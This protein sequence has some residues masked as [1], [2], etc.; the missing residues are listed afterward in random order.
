MPDLFADA[1]GADGIAV[2]TE[3]YSAD[4]QFRDGESGVFSI[5]RESPAYATGDTTMGL[6]GSVVSDIYAGADITFAST[7]NS[8]NTGV[9][10][11]GLQTQ[12]D[13]TTADGNTV[14]RNSSTL[15]TFKVVSPSLGAFEVF[16]DRSNN[17]IEGT[18]GTIA[19][20]ATDPTSVSTG[21]TATG[22]DRTVE[23]VFRAD[24]IEEGTTQDLDIA[25]TTEDNI[26]VDSDNTFRIKF[27][28]EDAVVTDE[29]G[30]IRPD[31][32]FV[33]VDE[34][35]DRDNGETRE[36]TTTVIQVTQPT[37]TVVTI[38][39]T[40]VTRTRRGS[41]IAKCPREVP[42]IG[43]DYNLNTLICISEQYDRNVVNV[44]FGL[45]IGWAQGPPAIRLR[46]K[47]VYR[48]LNNSPSTD[49]VK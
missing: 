36:V 22:E 35:T 47:N 39:G 37:F 11:A 46:G 21:T 3:N 8:R 49:Y 41:G 29:D 17:T 14:S 32:E 48:V 25:T 1:A 13:V 20:S 4:P 18:P 9:Q 10:L 34:T 16:Y 30:N 15:Q 44:P 6:A 27:D 24:D 19:G 28:I 12:A 23:I 40:E 31:G 42:L 33:F 7:T 26:L 43:T 45:G 38:D 2:N 5:T